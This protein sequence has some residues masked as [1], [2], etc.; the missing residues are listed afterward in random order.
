MLYLCLL[1]TLTFLCIYILFSGDMN[2]RTGNV[3]VCDY[4]REMDSVSEI[5]T[6]NNLVDEMCHVSQSE[7][8]EYAES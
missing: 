3:Q 7:D 6:R 8:L 1:V 4:F 5:S 2:S